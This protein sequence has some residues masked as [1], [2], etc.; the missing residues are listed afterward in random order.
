MA[1]TTTYFGSV[2]W[3]KKLCNT[4]GPMEIE[5]H[6]NYKKQT[7][8][9]HCCIATANGVQKLTVPVTLPAILSHGDGNIREVRISDHGNWRHLHWE[10]LASAY[11]M[12]P[13]YEYYADDIR[14]FFEKRW[15]F[16]F[17]FNMDIMRKMLDLLG[18]ERDIIPT[19]RY[20]GCN[21]VQPEHSTIGPYYQTFERRHGFLQGMSI[22]DLLFNEGPEAALYLTHK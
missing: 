21:D 9:N 19:E 7:P 1:L 5:A 14:P 10:A 11:G 6:E 17:D 12:S 22:L 16:L 2:D 20:V 15:E 8:R 13:F 4:S 3:Y 18:V